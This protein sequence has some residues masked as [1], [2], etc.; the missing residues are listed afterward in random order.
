VLSLPVAS[1]EL[2]ALDRPSDEVLARRAQ[3]VGYGRDGLV[4]RGEDN[5]VSLMM[6]LGVIPSSQ[7]ERREL[8]HAKKENG[9]ASHK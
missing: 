3:V 1:L 7:E 5:L 8:I 4:E 2:P 9:N 6:I